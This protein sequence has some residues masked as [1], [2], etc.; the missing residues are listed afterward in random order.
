MS[1]SNLLD[2]AILDMLTRSAST[3]EAHFGGDVMTYYGPIHDS[4]LREFRN[5]IEGL[6]ESRHSR[7]IIFMSTPGGIVQAAEKM[8]EIIRFHYKEVFFVVPDFAMSAGTVF[9]MSGD[10]VFM[11][12]SSSLGPIDPQVL[13]QTP[14]GQRYVPALG[15][16][17]KVELLIEKSKN[18]TITPAEFAILRDQ[19]LAVIRSYEQARDLSVELLKEWLF[20]YKFKS[21]TTHRTSK[22][23]KGQLVTPEEK[24]DRA[25]KIATLLCDNKVWHSHGRMIGIERLTKFLRLEIE[26]YSTDKKLRTLIREYHDT[27]TEYASR[28]GLTYCFHSARR[29]TL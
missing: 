23:K 9:V 5:F 26:D 19:N 7:L 20:T 11:D 28:F 4:L 18:D 2:D 24:R 12:Y 3:L 15:H 21:W 10:K 16:L 14:E 6:A 13:I 22:S 25:E 8:V 27:L 29:S 17:D 1:A